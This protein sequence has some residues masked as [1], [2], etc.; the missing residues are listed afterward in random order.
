M[1]WVMPFR[2]GCGHNK[3][4]LPCGEWFF[5]GVIN[6][7][8]GINGLMDLQALF[9]MLQSESFLNINWE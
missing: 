9:A 8:N 1:R 7:I 6:G 2:F 4:H 3:N 5:V